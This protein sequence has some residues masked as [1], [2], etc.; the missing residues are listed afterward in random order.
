MFMK[1]LLS[2]LLVFASSILLIAT[3]HVLAASESSAWIRSGSPTII[4]ADEYFTEKEADEYWRSYLG[5]HTQQSCTDETIGY[6]TG[7]GSENCWYESPVGKFT[8]YGNMIVPAGMQEAG[9]YKE[10]S[11]DRLIPLHGGRVLL[12]LAQSIDGGFAASFWKYENVEFVLMSTDT[13]EYIDSWRLKHEPDFVLRDYSGAPWLLDSNTVA[14]GFWASNNGRYLVIAS[15]TDEKMLRIDL[16]N[17][18]VLAIDFTLPS[19]EGQSYGTFAITDDGNQIFVNVLGHKS[20]ML[21]V[22]TCQQEPKSYVMSELTA[23]DTKDMTEWFRQHMSQ[24]YGHVRFATF[25]SDSQLDFQYLIPTFD[26]RYETFRMFAPNTYKPGMKYLAL[27]DS[28]ASGEGAERY[29]AGTDRRENRCHLSKRS[30]P[31]LLRGELDLPWMHSV[32]CSGAR[33]HNIIGPENIDDDLEDPARSNQWKYFFEDN[34]LGDYTPGR[35]AQVKFFSTKPDVITISVSG[36][37]AGFTEYLSEC[38]ALG[39]RNITCFEGDTERAPLAALIY[40]QYERLVG[41]YKQLRADMPIGGRVYALGYPH[42]VSEGGNCANNVRLDAKEVKLTRQLTNY[43][44]Y[45][46]ERA[47]AKAGVRYIDMSESLRGYRL[48]DEHAIGIHGV[49]VGFSEA[50]N[51]RVLSSQSYHP[52]AYGHT[53]MADVVARATKNFTVP[54]PR[55]DRSALEPTMADAASFGIFKD[56]RVIEEYDQVFRY[57]E[58]YGGRVILKN[59]V[60]RITIKGRYY[61]LP[62]NTTFAVKLYSS[63]IDLG[64]VTSNSEGDI[65]FDLSLPGNVESGFHRLRLFGTG[66]DGKP[67]ELRQVVYVAASEDDWDGDGIP[68]SKQT[69]AIAAL[70]ERG[71][72]D[73]KWCLVGDYGEWGDEGHADD[74]TAYGRQRTN[75]PPGS[76][77]RQV[78]T[79]QR[80]VRQNGIPLMFLRAANE[81]DL[82]NKSDLVLTHSDQR[83]TAENTQANQSQDRGGKSIVTLVILVLMSV[84]LVCYAY[85]RRKST[86]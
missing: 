64:V 13:S 3:P 40:Q 69:C 80:A 31:F 30:Y 28:F 18:S 14:T 2:L 25:V 34:E 19:D 38:A 15:Y 55:P 73:K 68:N 50:H 70:N 56:Q 36:N 41:V 8:S 17:F 65:E 48:C 51:N 16:Q 24:S 61:A 39:F 46:I 4:E 32:A 81:S 75:I 57:V 45:I 21:H 37:D 66:A 53:R 54:S 67:I 33:I 72:E 29:Y 10:G 12:E 20:R 11:S 44:N 7:A 76:S 59:K 49:S 58:A 43:L 47:A 71:E 9:L 6:R 60:P 74:H 83:G 27:G 23:C 63:P 52:T 42:I 86:S 78:E 85:M 5:P 22:D 82:Q 26:N 77:I 62:G 79:R 84:S 35:Y 1:R